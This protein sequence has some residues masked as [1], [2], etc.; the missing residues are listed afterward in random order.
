MTLTGR[1]LVLPADAAAFLQDAGKPCS[2]VERRGVWRHCT[3]Q[4]TPIEVEITAVDFTYGDSSA[5]LMLVTDQAPRRRRD[6]RLEKAQRM[7]CAGR[8]ADGIARHFSALFSMIEADASA[9]MDKPQ[10]L[11][12]AEQLE[13]IRAAVTRA[14]ELAGR[15]LA[16]GGKQPI[17]LEPLDLNGI[18]RHMNPMLRRLLG[19]G[20]VLEN[21]FGFHT[22]AVLGD[23]PLLESVMVHLALN[24]R[25]AMNDAG[26][27]TLRTTKVRVTEEEAAREPHA[28]AGEFM[29]LDVRDTG[30]GMASE[31]KEALFEPF[32]STKDSD[33]RPGLGMACVHGIVTQHSGW[34]DCVSEA[35]VGTEFRVYLPC[36]PASA[37]VNDAASPSSS[38][39]TKGTILLVEAEDRV[40]A[41]ARFVLNHQGYRVIEADGSAT[42]LVLWAGQA[43]TVDLLLTD[44]NLP[45]DLSGAQLADR[46]RQARPGLKVVYATDGQSGAE[47]NEPAPSDDLKCIAKPYNPE[48]LL[49]A[50]Q[51]LL[52]P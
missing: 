41:L 46:F 8:I 50:V 15:L 37:C 11:R 16:A 33:R 23:R 36:A 42:A 18:I 51:S 22:P 44:L 12:S 6:A 3:K 48:G 9:L 20:I 34:I 5:R 1:D 13:H 19:E 25:E 40:R 26:T 39:A 28:R 38:S 10:D 47:C 29:R 52:N 2:G 4:G 30:C 24:A 31:V 49:Q 27:L 32:F 35:G 21:V 17:K 43:S 7:K 45:G 14:S